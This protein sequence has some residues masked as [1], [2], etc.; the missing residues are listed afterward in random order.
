MT[1]TGS[2]SGQ[3]TPYA[4]FVVSFSLTWRNSGQLQGF[5]GVG[6][7]TPEDARIFVL[8]MRTLGSWRKGTP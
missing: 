4:P 1:E 5:S 2:L 3:A 7:R 8:A 6:I